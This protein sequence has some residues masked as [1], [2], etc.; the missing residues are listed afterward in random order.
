[1]VNKKILIGS[2]IGVIAIGSLIFGSYLILVPK[3][4]EPELWLENPTLDS[5]IQPDWFWEYGTEG[6]I[7]DM[8]LIA[9]QNQTNYRI[10]GEKETVKLIYG[11]PNSSTSPNWDIFNNSDFMLPDLAEINTAGCYVYH[12]LNESEDGGLGQIHN[13]PSV[14]FKKNISM[15]VDMSDY[16]I[17]DASFEVVINGSVNINV[18]TFNDWNPNATTPYVDWN[19]F[20]IGDSA[21]FYAV[22]S[23]TKN[24]YP[25]P[26]GSFETKDVAL[27]QGDLA[28]NFTV[29]L[30]LNNTEL[31]YED[32]KDLINALNTALRTDNQNFTITLGLDIYCEDNR[33]AGDY[34]LWNYLIFKTCNLSVTY[35]KKIDYFTSISLNQNGKEISGTNLRITDANLN[36]KYKINETWPTSATLSEIRIYINNIFYDR[37]TV[38]LSSMNASYQEVRFGGLDITDYVDLNTEVNLSIQIF[39]AD[40]FN[41]DKV[42]EISIDDIYLYITLTDIG[43]N[44]TPIIIGLAAAIV[45]LTTAFSLYFKIFQFPPMV[46]KIR[47]LNKNVRRG[48]KLKPITLENREFIVKNTLKDKIQVLNLEA[49]KNETEISGGD[50]DKIS[51]SIQ[52]EMEGNQSQ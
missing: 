7:S 26:L 13:F 45:G 23:D 29:I 32:K 39:L 10:L 17:T 30:E 51:D 9:S 12:Y 25:F 21:N 15:P 35:E 36:F 40:N 33:G 44:W 42:I 34:D 16:F 2:I 49:L 48:R 28:P 41:L 6:D 3:P 31:N 37:K 52:K 22:L 11:T 20:D 1:M 24:S 4:S 38:R 27:G 47:K 46:R 19:R 50:N 18:D 43:T 8:D 5:P 14:H